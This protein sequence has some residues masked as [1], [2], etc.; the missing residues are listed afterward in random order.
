MAHTYLYNCLNTTRSHQ[1]V[2]M[3]LPAAHSLLILLR[4]LLSFSLKSSGDAI[5]LLRSICLFRLPVS[6]SLCLSV[7]NVCEGMDVALGKYINQVL[8]MTFT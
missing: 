6:F 1:Q 7:S 3:T 8:S 5:N 4:R 2:F